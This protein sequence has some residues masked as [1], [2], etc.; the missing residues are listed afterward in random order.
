[1][2]RKRKCNMDKLEGFYTKYRRVTYKKGEIILAQGAVPGSA[3]AVKSGAVRLYTFTSEYAERSV[4]FV[5]SG[6]VFP[7]CWLF[8]KTATT[9]FYYVAHTDCELYVIDRQ[10]FQSEIQGSSAMSY[11]LLDDSIN[12]YVTKA[13]Q[14]TALEQT[15]AID[16]ILHTF[17]YFCL[18]YGRR[19]MNDVVRIGIPLTQKDIASF[20]GLA[21]ETVAVEMSKVRSKRIFTCKNRMYTVNLTNLRAFMDDMQGEDVTIMSKK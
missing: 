6:E 5:V 18:R 4:S 15:R 1:M 14:I 7:I 19:L 11:A 13:L 10:A 21:R 17:N 8:S 12:D 9:L 3:F 2:R 16:R 20:T